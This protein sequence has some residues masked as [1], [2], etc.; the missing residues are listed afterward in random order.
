MAHGKRYQVVD[1]DV[2][3]GL[4]EDLEEREIRVPHEILVREEGER[5]Q[6][7]RDEGEGAL[8]P[9]FEERV[10]EP[11]EVRAHERRPDQAQEDKGGNRLVAEEVVAFV[12]VLLDHPEEMREDVA[13]EI[14][15][16]VAIVVHV[17][18][19]RL[20]ELCQ[21]A[22]HAEIEHRIALVAVVGLEELRLDALAYHPSDG[23]AEGH[24]EKL[25]AHHAHEHL[26]GLG[27][28]RRAAEQCGASAPRLDRRCISDSVHEVALAQ[29]DAAEVLHRALHLSPPG[30]NV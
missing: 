9:R 27:K 5:M 20:D 24:L 10:G 23:G 11:E 8:L 25:G 14:W 1:H 29:R 17:R 13:D 28:R 2:V 4:D 18:P 7:L 30:H 26:E 6:Y 21:N 16:Q 15:E 19:A 12:V 22:Q 3:V